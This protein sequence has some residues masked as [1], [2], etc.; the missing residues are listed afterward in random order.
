MIT[1][2]A[3]VPGWQVAPVEYLQ[4]KGTVD[5]KENTLFMAGKLGI[6]TQICCRYIRL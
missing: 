4:T 1:E 5:K 2:A 3:K 6:D